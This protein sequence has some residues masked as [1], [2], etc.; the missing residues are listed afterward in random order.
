[1]LKTKLPKASTGLYKYC[2]STPILK[3]LNVN[4]IETTVDISSLDLMGTIFCN[5]LR[6]SSFYSHLMHVCGKLIGHNDLIA[7]VK[8][9][10]FQHEVSFF[11]FLLISVMST[12]NNSFKEALHGRRWV[13][14]HGKAAIVEP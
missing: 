7:S 5:P 10:S 6:A 4:K 12:K 8:T 11:N 1:M 14:R 3:A 2:K 9:I 13:G